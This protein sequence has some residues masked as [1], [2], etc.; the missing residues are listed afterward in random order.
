MSIENK[1]NNYKLQFN[2]HELNSVRR[3]YPG[4]G[5]PSVVFFLND[6]TKWPPLYFYKGGSKE[7][8]QELKQFFV[9]RKDPTVIF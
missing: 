4:Y 1:I 9:F 8:L 3:V 2:I 7:F 5:I 6:G